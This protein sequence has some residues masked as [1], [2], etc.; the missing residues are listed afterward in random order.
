MNGGVL[1][2]V[3][4]VMVCILYSG[5]YMIRTAEDEPKRVIDL[6]TQTLICDFVRVL[7]SSCQCPSLVEQH[8]GEVFVYFHGGKVD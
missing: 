5:L 1:L 3:V 7:F 6:S 2:K 8:S 4:T